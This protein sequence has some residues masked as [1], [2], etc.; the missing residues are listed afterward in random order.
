M[1][2]P[3]LRLNVS[4]DLGFFR[5]QLRQLSAVASS[6]FNAPLRVKFD[7]ASLNK[8]IQTL[9][10]YV[11]NKTFNIKINTNLEAE[12]KAA[13]RLVLALQ[14]VQQASGKVKGSLPLGT[15]G[16]SQTAGKGG[17][18]AAEIKTLF[19]ASIQ[20]GLLDEKT[21]GKTRAQMVAA[22]GTIGR[23]S[24]KGLLDGLES[25]DPRLQQAA[26]TLGKSLIKSFKDVLGIASPSKE[27]KKIGD[28]AGKG[29]EQGL[30]RA[31]EIAEQSAT[32]QMQRMLDRLARMAL[33]MGGMSA[34]QISQQVRGMKALSPFDWQ[35]TTPSRGVGAGPSST[36]RMLPPG[37]TP[38]GLP[39]TAIGS[40][41]LLMGDILDPSLKNAAREAANAFVDTIRQ[42]LNEAIRSVN[43]RDLGNALRPALTG[44]RVAGFLAPG[45]GRVS[46]PYGTG[47]LGRDGETR[48]ELF[49]RREREARMRSALRGV[50]VMGEGGVA[51]RPP[52]SY[53]YAYR[54]ARPQSA[55]VPYAPGGAMV[56]SGPG[57]MPPGGGTGGG[58]GNFARRGGGGGGFNTPNLPG[59]GL[60][61]EIGQE[62]AFATKQVLLF[63][64]AY[65]ALAFA[66][67]FPAQ[68]GQAVAALQSFNN[69]L[70]AISPSAKEVQASND[71]ILQLV[72]KY[73]IPLQSARDGFTKL[74]ASMQSAGFGGD[75]VRDIFTGI[76]KA[77]ATFGMSADKV[78]RVNYAFAQMASKGQVMSEELKGQLGDVLPGAL[79]IFA[80]AAGFKGPD[81]IQKFSEALED[82]AYKGQAMKQ[83]LTN[84]GIVMNQE[85]GPGAEGAARTFQG[86]INRMQN[87]LLSLYEAFEPAAVGF[88]N[89]VVMPLT[90]GIKQV[91]DGFNAFF[92][93]QAAQTTGGSALAKQLNELKPAF[94]GIVTNIQALI[95]SF[96]LFG[97]LLLN[98]AKFLT[99]L[100]GNPIV[101]FLLK[102]YTN[103]LL[104]NTAFTLLGGRVLL[105]AIASINA[106]IARIVALSVTMNAL[107]VATTRAGTSIAGT[108]LQMLL[109][110]RGAAGAVGP[111]TTLLGSLLRLAGI[112]TIAIAVTIAISGLMQLAETEARIAK[113]RGEK[114]PVG[115]AG[116]RPIETA[117][118]RYTGATKEKVQADQR[119]Q[120]EYV[121]GL[122]GQLAT[123]K[124][125]QTKGG[126]A[127]SQ[128]AVGGLSNIL[129]GFTQE[130]TKAKITELELKIRNAEEV[131]NL[132]P[133]KY[134][135]EAERQR[136][137][138]T[139]TTSVT[140][141][142]SD[143]GA[144]LDTYDRSKLD[145]IQQQAEQEQLALDRR[146]Q[147]NIIS[148]TRYK[149][150]SAALALDTA[151]LEEAE[152][153]RLA[154]MATNRDNL[155]AQ[156]KQLKLADL[157][158]IYTNNL[159]IA[160]DKYNVAVEGARKELEGPFNSAIDTA[161][162]SIIEQ[163][164]LLANLKDG[165]GELTPD[166]QAYLQVLG[167]TRDISKD[168]LLLM[169]GKIAL[170]K[171]VIEKQIA[172]NNEVKREQM[173]RGLR[174][175]LTL[176][177]TLDPGLELREKIRQENPF[178]SPAA[179]E[180]QALLQEQVNAAQK[181]KEDLQSIA[182]TIGN[183]FGEAFKGIITGTSSV[184]EALAGLFQSIADSFA[185]MVAQMIAEWLKAQLLKGFQ[186]IFNAALPG[187]GAVAG[188]IGG[189]LSS[190][191]S[192]GTSSAI[193][194]SAAGWGAAF[195]TNLQFADGG[196][197]TGGFRAFANGG[198]VT[199][200]T[201]GLVGEGRYNEAIVPLPDGKSIPVDL[202]GVA[203]G[204]GGEVTSNIVVNINNGQMQGNGNSNGSE[205]GRKIE[206]AVKQVLVSEL[207]PGGILSSGRR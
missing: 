183:A 89:A 72:D 64:T 43:V 174:G 33:M 129:G 94:E 102:V 92:T 138:V 51:G 78:D 58:P 12:I 71:L 131:L 150:D 101:G 156:D 4:L 172:L 17:F 170:L 177:Q 186:S 154:T 144:K 85:F 56:Y 113:L 55:I 207:R 143:K 155:S 95:P 38:P 81:A 77:A 163:E 59:A 96:Q 15:K 49:A 47:R 50:D 30:L 31:M 176:A 82:G 194:T 48:A 204:V 28:D 188:G 166:Q 195:N 126:Q 187:L 191:F 111:V 80:E 193:D 202:G 39:G 26:Q 10:R 91:T 137:S 7:R 114:N 106:A 200:P 142:G 127:L 79:G 67:N 54:G 198:M 22:L 205:L 83:L 97:G 107:G 104:V 161:N 165:I 20:G 199:G 192:A 112:G 36:G 167:L 160:Q 6:E 148:E 74:Y 40:Q 46:N 153:L 151:K 63:G 98:V 66:T 206:G 9:N 60:V 52:S 117:E 69:T 5:Q 84:V 100:A 141:T 24:I 124:A 201:M 140:G 16:L 146:R 86:V 149:I 118:R 19:N 134:Q 152:K 178:L 108:Q 87:S 145:F 53:S 65:K 123:L 136:A 90:S 180:E 164:M 105:G 103:V 88:L 169:E 159:A 14:R 37:Y 128:T 61:R 62:F 93:G 125:T 158:I 120:Q 133:N 2:A 75:E 99:T 29:F 122:R 27:F 41:K 173:L 162:S 1:A 197:A 196:I 135:T 121:A 35:A 139:A 157:Q 109:L 44:S 175:Q 184:R 119:A 57:G 168:E 171:G 179:V 132:N 68:V 190:G 110:Q 116:P 76:S 21:L 115:P 13:D 45:V 3:E 8:E 32:R 73:N 203:G 130:N 23:D 182:S 181:A 189:G 34:S 11:N 185:D 25:G 18:S 42:G 147:Q 70:K